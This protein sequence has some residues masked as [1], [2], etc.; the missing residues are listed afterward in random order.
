MFQM[1]M[2]IFTN[3]AYGL[4]LISG[5][6]G[7]DYVKKI[8]CFVAENCPLSHSVIVLFA[9]VGVYVEVNRRH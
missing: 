2:Q 8:Y 6:N 1:A 7:G 5:D 9:T 4:L 3:M